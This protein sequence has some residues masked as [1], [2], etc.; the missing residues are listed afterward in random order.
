MRRSPPHVPFA[1]YGGVRVSVAEPTR[2]R[3]FCRRRP[4]IP[5]FYWPLAR[6][7]GPRG[8]TRTSCVPAAGFIPRGYQTK[9]GHSKRFKG[10]PCPRRNDPPVRHR[11]PMTGPQKK[12]K[13]KHRSRRRRKMHSTHLLL[14]EPIRMA[15]ILEP[16][17]PVRLL[18]LSLSI[19]GR[20]R[21]LI[22][23][24]K[25]CFAC[26]EFLPCHD[27]DRGDAR[28]Q[29]PV[30]G[31]DLRLPQGWHVGY[32]SRSGFTCF[33]LLG[34]FVMLDT[35][36]PELQVVNKSEKA[37]SLEADGY[38]ILT[39]D[40]EQEASSELLPI[41]FSGLSKASNFL[42]RTMLIVALC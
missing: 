27:Q 41:N 3:Q 8:R 6:E 24:A 30:G 17:K 5:C 15:S 39:P 33:A 37:I 29:I 10:S 11:T 2:P 28:P 23:D 9:F 21:S 12:P 36:G 31:G 7:H 25:C 42:L 20:R 13:Q 22:A 35:V 4:P 1:R 40:Q 32:A 14:E 18:S 34:C 26:A 38:V 16:S 19:S